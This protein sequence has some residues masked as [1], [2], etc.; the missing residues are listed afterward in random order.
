[1]KLD[2]TAI[3]IQNAVAAALANFPYFKDKLVEIESFSMGYN[4]D[5]ATVGIKIRWVK[6]KEDE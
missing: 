4:R 5:Y 6:E 1:M 2:K 3:D